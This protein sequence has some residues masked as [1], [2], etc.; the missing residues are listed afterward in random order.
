MA[1]RREIAAQVEGLDTSRE[2]PHESPPAAHPRTARAEP[3]ARSRIML[4]RALDAEPVAAAARA[5]PVTAAALTPEDAFDALY[6]YAAPGLIRQAH[7]L[8]GSLRL[9]FESA[10]HA[11]HRAWDHWPEV[12]RDTD[13]V[14]WLRIQTHAYALSPWHR[15][16][17]LFR[18]PSPAPVDPLLR[19]IRELPPRQR[20]ALVLCDGL[21]LSVSEAAAETEAGTAATRNRLLHARAALHELR[22]AEPWDATRDSLAVFL[23]SMSGSTVS[24]P[25]SVR[26][27]SER[28][29]RMLTRTVYTAVA[30]LIALV[31]YTIATTP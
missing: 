4:L 24:H 5:E 30:V 12:A 7:V 11:F 16:R 10:E 19:A 28:R 6:V 18:R 20:R 22:S 2:S 14:G 29:I 15:F 17:R 31:A 3:S 8:T 25:V 26:E 27:D 9:A 13:P 23:E 21:G 1:R